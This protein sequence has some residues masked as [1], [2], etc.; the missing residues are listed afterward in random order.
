MQLHLRDVLG[1]MGQR[2]PDGRMVP[3]DLEGYTY[4]EATR[5]GGNHYALQQAVLHTADAYASPKPGKAKHR[6]AAD[7]KRDGRST[8]DHFRHATRELLMPDGSVRR[9]KIFL[10]TAF[11]G[12]PVRL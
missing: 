7:A 2:G 1:L 12:Q 11:N 8:V 3:F 10:I 9:V 6:P 4:N 5:E